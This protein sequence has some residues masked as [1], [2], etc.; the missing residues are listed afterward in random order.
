[1]ATRNDP[2]EYEAEAVA[3][4][5]R[6]GETRVSIAG[7]TAR[8]LDGEAAGDVPAI[9]EEVLRSPGTPLGDRARALME[10]RFGT[11]F[12]HVRVHADANA[13]RSAQAIRARAY[14][15]GASIVFAAKQFTLETPEGRA[16]LAHEL[17]HVAQEGGD[18]GVVRRSPQDV[19][20]VSSTL[21]SKGLADAREEAEKRRVSS[22][23]ASGVDRTG[24]DSESWTGANE[25]KWEDGHWTYTDESGVVWNYVLIYEDKP[26]TELESEW[27]TQETRFDPWSFWLSKRERVVHQGLRAVTRVK[28]TVTFEGWLPSA[29][30]V[31]S[32]TGSVPK[33]EKTWLATA[34]GLV[35]TALD[36]GLGPKKLVMAYRAY[37]FI[38]D[39][40]KNGLFQ[41][42]ENYAINKL[43]DK[44]IDTALNVGKKVLKGSPK[45]AS[46]HHDPA[47]KPTTK[48]Q[49]H[50][51]RKLT[52]AEKD[53]LRAEARKIAETARGK[54]LPYGSDVHHRIPLEFAHLQ[55]HL[56][57]NRLENLI[58]ITDREAREHTSLGLGQ[59][60]HL[61]LHELWQKQLKD[62]PDP[63]A[64][65]IENIASQID[66]YIRSERKWTVERLR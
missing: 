10:P 58:V 37:Q 32:V 11:D 62:L 1:L 12:G 44:A 17:A 48:P 31:I 61:R 39:V 60:F 23:K 63:T 46:G 6:A 15:S 26:V 30:E 54:R 27:E 28:P 8:G 18:A 40:R 21:P 57:P 34:T 41:A 19:H 22:D 50:L 43:E 42:G 53:A 20:G 47:G 36:W 35:E 3:D 7:A 52:G 59:S 49:F 51:T 64:S 2:L 24:S 55:P 38:S 25:I 33:Q 14:A 13:A 45:G 9:V 4:R 65:E 5:V 56:D 29:S 66:K 16:L